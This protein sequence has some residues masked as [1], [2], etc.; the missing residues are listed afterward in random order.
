MKL[1]ERSEDP[2]YAM[3][4][5]LPLDLEYYVENQLRGPVDRIFEVV[6]PRYSGNDVFQGKAT[7]SITSTQ[8]VSKQ[9]GL[10][11]FVSTIYKCNFFSYFR[12]ELL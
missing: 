10:G 3:E 11:M 4:N 12:F 6:F 5:E 2:V 8:Q 7:L 9:K 1:Y